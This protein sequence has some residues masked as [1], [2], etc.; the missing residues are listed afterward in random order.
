MKQFKETGSV[1]DRPQSGRP[2]LDMET[3][4]S[5]GKGFKQSSQK[6]LK[7]PSLELRIPKTGVHKIITVKLPQ[8]PSKIQMHTML[9]GKYLVL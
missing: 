7:Q 3:A 2:G 1:N 4:S 6:S 5:A 8:Q 9:Q